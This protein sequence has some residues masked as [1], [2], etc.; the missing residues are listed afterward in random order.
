MKSRVVHILLAF[1]LLGLP[2]VADTHRPAL[3]LTQV[4][5]GTVKYCLEQ[6][7]K[8]TFQDESLL[9]KYEGQTQSYDR[10]SIA[11]LHYVNDTDVPTRIDQNATSTVRSV[12]FYD[13]ALTVYTPQAELL[14]VYNLSGQCVWSQTSTAHAQIH[15]TYQSLTPGVYV[16]KCGT[17]TYKFVVR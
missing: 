9:V 14:A 2:S 11:S 6:L 5:G 15:L 12:T 10:T 16:L 8:L 17:Q 1:C 3:L 4:D 13:Q 7:P